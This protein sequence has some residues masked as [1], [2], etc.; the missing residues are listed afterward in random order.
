MKL[1]KL[2]KKYCKFCDKYTENNLKIEKKNKQSNT[3]W[4]NRQ[5]QRRHSHGN[6]GKFSKRPA[7][8]YKKTRRPFLL[9][10]CGVC[11]KKTH[12]S[13]KRTKRIEIKK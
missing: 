10:T 7:K 9:N 6:K 12:L 13:Y 5:K 2:I 8:R 3:L 11:D 1:P 4:I